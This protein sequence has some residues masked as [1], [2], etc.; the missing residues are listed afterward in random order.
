MIFGFEGMI[1]TKGSG[2]LLFLFLF[3]VLNKKSSHLWKKCGK[4]KDGNYKIYWI[5]VTGYDSVKFK[6]KGVNEDEEA[7]HR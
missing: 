5:A 6:I 3:F 2:G 1:L 7:L 4:Y